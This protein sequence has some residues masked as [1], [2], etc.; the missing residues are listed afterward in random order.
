MTE[1]E[2]RAWYEENQKS[3]AQPERAEARHIFIPTLDHPPEEAKAKL[4][5]AL[6]DLTS[7]TKDF[8]TLAKEISQDPATKDHGGS[9]GWM[10]RDRLPAD[11]SAPV[12]SLPLHKPTLVR[13]RIGW[14]LI[15]VT[16][17]TPAE[18]RSFEAAKPEVLAALEAIKRRQAATDF[19]NA[20]RRF[21]AEKIDVYH[22]MVAE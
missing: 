4:E 16:A 14:H 9:L 3:L 10:T 6:A 17:R 18:P 8:A 12:F 5:T 2:A 19:R 21:E 20:L 1:E 22:D 11:L 13:S 15:E 7:G